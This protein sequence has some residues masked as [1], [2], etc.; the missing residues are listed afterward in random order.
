MLCVLEV[1]HTN[2]VYNASI[3]GIHSEKVLEVCHINKVT[4]YNYLFMN[5]QSKRPLVKTLNGLLFLFNWI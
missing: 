2:K 3:Q 5:N 1:C 4:V